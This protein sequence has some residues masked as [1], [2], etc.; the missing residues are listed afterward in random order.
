LKEF[1][2][3]YAAFE[4]WFIPQIVYIKYQFE[5]PILF[6][7]GPTICLDP[8]RTVLTYFKAA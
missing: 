3:F 1:S 6:I 4:A 5:V 7:L 2:F 8:K